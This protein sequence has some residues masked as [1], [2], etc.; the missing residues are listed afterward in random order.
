[1]HTRL[2]VH[3]LYETRCCAQDN[4]ASIDVASKE[5][6][7]CLLDPAMDSNTSWMVSKDLGGSQVLLS[8]RILQHSSSLMKALC[9]HLFLYHK[10]L[11]PLSHP[12]DIYE[13]EN[14]SCHHGERLKHRIWGCPS[15]F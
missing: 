14:Y 11:A 13:E 4:S 10:A 1:M 15:S 12:T 3:V 2:W 7:Y 5:I 9:R 8:S 6:I